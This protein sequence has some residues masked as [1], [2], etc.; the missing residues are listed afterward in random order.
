MGKAEINVEAV[1]GR[2]FS[3]IYWFLNIADR[4]N[5]SQQVIFGDGSLQCS[6]LLYDF[7]PEPKLLAPACV[8][9]NFTSLASLSLFGCLSCGRIPL[10]R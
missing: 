2:R 9:M 4:A 10:R 1:A 8:F 7:L 6:L 5:S 3:D